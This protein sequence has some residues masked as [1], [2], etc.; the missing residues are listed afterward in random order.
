MGNS[1]VKV[2]VFL[3]RVFWVQGETLVGCVKITCTQETKIRGVRLHWRGWERTHWQ[4]T[5]RDSNGNT[6][7]HRYWGKRFIVNETITLYGAPRGGKD[8][9][10]PVGEY[11]YPFSVTLPWDIPPS[12]MASCAEIVY[13]VE[14]YVDIAWKVDPSH[15]L[16]IVVHGSVPMRQ[17][18]SAPPVA[19]EKS[20]IIPTCCCCGD[21]GTYRIAAQIDKCVIRLGEALRI[22]GQVDLNTSKD[23]QYIVCEVNFEYRY[24]APNPGYG[25]GGYHT[26]SG[27]RTCFKQRK[28]LSKRPVKGEDMT[29]E[30]EWIINLPTN[31]P[32]TT[33]GSLVRIIWYAQIRADV[34]MAS[35]PELNLPFVATHAALETDYAHDLQSPPRQFDNVV[36]AQAREWNYQGPVDFAGCAPPALAVGPM[37]LPPEKMWSYEPIGGGGMAPS[38]SAPPPPIYKEQPA[39]VPLVAALPTGDE[40]PVAFSPNEGDVIPPPPIPSAPPAP[41]NMQ[42]QQPWQTSSGYSPYQAGNMH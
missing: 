8:F 25:R 1:S 30:F 13:F 26:R 38:P 16:Q 5:E 14:G 40:N 24:W 2:G 36:D 28:T 39:Y 33:A 42:Q 35:D 41:P 32:A 3:P 37:A 12:Y 6:R 34:P 19:D 21:S 10:L 4:R 27:T 15:K 22:H 9:T 29:E 7:T 11:S 23:I 31:V 18:L 20:G 17:F